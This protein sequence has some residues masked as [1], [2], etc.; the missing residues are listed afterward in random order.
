[1][2]AGLAL[3][4]GMMKWLFTKVLISLSHDI[5]IIFSC[6]SLTR[7]QKIELIGKKYFILAKYYSGFYKFQF[8]T[9]KIKLHGR[10]LFFEQGEGIVRLQSILVSHLTAIREELGEGVKQIVDVGANVGHFTRAVSFEYPKSRILAIEPVAAIAKILKTNL[11]DIQ[12]RVD[13]RQVAIG[14]C[15]SRVRMRIDNDWL[16][17][18]KIEHQSDEGKGA[19]IGGLKA[20]EIRLEEVEMTTLDEI[21]DGTFDKVDLLKIDVEGYESEVLIGATRTLAK[22]RFLLIETSRN[23]RVSFASLMGKLQ[24]KGY[25]FELRSIINYRGVKSKY[26]FGVA[27]LLLE[28]IQ[29]ET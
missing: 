27:D 14:A 26:W 10:D 7:S 12:D 6:P 15:K 9:T 8:G 4:F 24:G 28:N 19:E 18:A 13:L 3:S 20:G 1:M 21:V 29:F 5:D 16:A 2:V 11:E 25:D 23:S 22:T 17:E